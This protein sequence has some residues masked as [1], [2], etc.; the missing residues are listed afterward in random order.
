MVINQFGTKKAPLIECLKC[1][2]KC[3]RKVDYERHCMTKKHKINENQWF[4]MVKAPKSTK[5]HPI[6]L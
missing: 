6:Y 3:S 1:N 5:K 4:S 2:F